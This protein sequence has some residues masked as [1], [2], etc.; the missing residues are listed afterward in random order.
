MTKVNRNSKE[1]LPT[2]I[3][4]D[5]YFYLTNRDYSDYFDKSSYIHI[6]LEDNNFGLNYSNVK[7]CQ[8]N[9]DP[10]S[11]P[12]GAASGCDFNDFNTLEYYNTEHYSNSGKFYYKYYVNSSYSYSVISYNGSYSSGNLYVTSDYKDLSDEDSSDELSTVAIICIVLASL[13]VLAVVIFILIRCF[14]RRRSNKNDP[15]VQPYVAAPPVS[16][17]MNQQIY[18][19]AVPYQAY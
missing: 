12:E 16:H 14:K 18:N 13:I 1:Y 4:E 10:D 15:L 6:L 17:P 5:K 7:Y 3:S 19:P 8:T 11:Y 9:T 2:N